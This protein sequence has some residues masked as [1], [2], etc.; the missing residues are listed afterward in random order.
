MS[1]NRDF[2]RIAAAWLAQGPT[3]LT[4]RV[5]DAA[6]DEVHLTHQ[7]RRST[8]LWRTPLLNTP[9]RFAAAIVIVAI[10]GFAGLN[11]V[12]DHGVGGSPTPSPTVGATPTLPVPVATPIDPTT[13]K[14]FRSGRY[15]YSAAAPSDWA[16][17]AASQ[18]WAGESG[19][20]VWA[21][22]DNA[23]WT[24]RF[25][26][27]RAGVYLVITGVSLLIPKGATEQSAIDGY[28]A[29]IP[30][31]TLGPGATPGPSPTSACRSTTS[32]MTSITIDG[33]IGRLSTTCATSVVFVP[34]GGR[35]FIFSISDPTE[36][37]TLTAF[38]S[39]VKL[40]AN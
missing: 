39:T 22:A 25:F 3:E 35:L 29:P 32:D 24:D 14:P 20:E 36:F 11:L 1:T 28:M 31:A 23:P 5:L 2:D 26:V 38:L 15:G 13:W 10:V 12:G 30:E 18:D 7:R 17:L 16:T 37:A 40:P 21:S 4:D 34:L 33:R 8:V 9:L 19:A 27:N 6:L